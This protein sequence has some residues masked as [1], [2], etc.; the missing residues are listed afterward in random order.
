MQHLR[1]NVWR[2]VN[3]AEIWFVQISL[4]WSE[5][6]LKIFACMTTACDDKKPTIGR[7]SIQRIHLWL[8]MPVWTSADQWIKIGKVFFHLFTCTDCIW[9]P[10][11]WDVILSKCCLSYQ[12]FNRRLHHS[13]PTGYGILLWH[14][15]IYVLQWE[16]ESLKASS[17][18]TDAGESIP[19]LGPWRICALHAQ[20]WTNNKHSYSWHQNEIFKIVCRMCIG[21]IWG[22]SPRISAN[23]VISQSQVGSFY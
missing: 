16:K 4:L 3:M 10:E 17:V 18:K 20:P 14:P 22:L 2:Y 11:Q 8:C 7:P 15:T 21:F 12:I 6:C 19:V 9:S 5:Q 23:P 1:A 13:D